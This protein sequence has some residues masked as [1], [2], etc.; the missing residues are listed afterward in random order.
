MICRTSTN[1]K[2]TS[3]DKNTAD[4]DNDNS[5]KNKSKNMLKVMSV[6]RPSYD[7]IK[8]TIDSRSKYKLYTS[9]SL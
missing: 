2:N 3:K 5:I 1:I 7:I 6:H 4:D 9:I 8:F